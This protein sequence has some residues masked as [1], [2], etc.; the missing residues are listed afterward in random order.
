[1]DPKEFIDV[2]EGIS[3]MQLIFQKEGL[4]VKEDILEKTRRKLWYLDTPTFKLKRN[5]FFLRI[6]EYEVNKPF[7]ITLKCRH[8]DRYLV[9]TFDFSNSSKDMS[10]KFEEDI[11]IPFSSN[12]SL[13]ASFNISSLHR[14]TNFK[15]LK[16]IFPNLNILGIDEKDR[17]EKV[18][19]FEARE[20][21]FQAGTFELTGKHSLNTFLTLW[22]KTDSNTRSS[23]P[24]VAEFTFRYGA[25]HK[26][27]KDAT[28]LE[29][30]PR[31][32]V[33]LAN[34]LCQILQD[35]KMAKHSGLNTKTEF[36]YNTNDMGFKT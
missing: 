10:I 9:C 19:E 33:L 16:R 26:V 29:Q 28:I 3:N 32:L 12:F 15:D 27:A 13:S 5:S 30:F 20:V 18:N 35:G 31:S 36:A 14:F 21:V 11:A 7:E 4:S 25:N 34:N 6:R 1:M 2:K 24:L 22:Y 17:L 8:P 23:T